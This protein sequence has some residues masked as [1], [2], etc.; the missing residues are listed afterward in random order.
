[1][2]GNLK[3]MSASPS[4]D[5]FDIEIYQRLS[6]GWWFDPWQDNFKYFLSSMYKYH[7]DK[8]NIEL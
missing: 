3:V 7:F 1:V 5:N 8:P 4:R 2:L 6:K